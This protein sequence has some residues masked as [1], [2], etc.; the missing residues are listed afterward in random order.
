M[1]W[2]QRKATC[3]LGQGLT[4]MYRRRWG[5][6]SEFYWNR[7]E[8]QC[9]LQLWKS[10]QVNNMQSGVWYELCTFILSS[11]AEPGVLSSSGNSP[12]AA[13]AYMRKNRKDIWDGSMPKTDLLQSPISCFSSG[14]KKWLNTYCDIYISM[15]WYCSALQ[16]CIPCSEPLYSALSRNCNLFCHMKVYQSVEHRQG[17]VNKETLIMMMISVIRSNQICRIM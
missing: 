12:P 13:A 9:G 4:E 3:F 11:W 2:G 16:S 8:I 7:E 6:N 10:T 14:R 15:Q 17:I 5:A 1:H